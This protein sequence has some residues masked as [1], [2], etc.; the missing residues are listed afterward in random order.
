MIRKDLALSRKASRRFS[1]LFY[2]SIFFMMF[3]LT[4]Y[5]GIVIIHATFDD[6][7]FDIFK[8]ISFTKNYHNY[9]FII[10]IQQFSRIC[11]YNFA[12]EKM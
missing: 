5:V 12:M 10:V 2:C 8:Y 3:V 7:L 4:V 6:E 1:F 9:H 11:P